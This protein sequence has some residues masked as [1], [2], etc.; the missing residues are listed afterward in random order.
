MSPRVDTL[1]DLCDSDGMT[2]T[3]TAP[4]TISDL[5]DAYDGLHAAA[6]VNIAREYLGLTVDVECG[7]EDDDDTLSAE[8]CAA[9]AAWLDGP[10]TL[11]VTDD[12]GYEIDRRPATAEQVIASY[13]VVDG[14]L[15][16]VDEDGD[17]IPMGSSVAHGRDDL[18]GAY[19]LPS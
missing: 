2:N 8:Q 13:A 19:C 10:H 5:A 14:G 3:A 18:R 6:L 17:V 11:I 7:Y 4:T 15:I 1:S 9:V 16:L 12:E